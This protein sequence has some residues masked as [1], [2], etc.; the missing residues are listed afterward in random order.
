[1]GALGDAVLR[2]HDRE[3]AEGVG[4]DD[5]G[6]DVQERTVQVFDGVGLGEDEHLVAALERGAAEVIGVQI[7]QLEVRTRRA[8]VDEDSFSQ[9]REV[10]VVRARSSEGRSRGGLHWMF[11]LPVHLRITTL[12]T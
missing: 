4:L 6:A 3:R 5:V 10:G 8:V 11:R 2:E 12:A 9:R 7:H 1:M